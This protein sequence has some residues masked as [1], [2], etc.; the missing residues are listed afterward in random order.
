M[1]VFPL[2][3]QRFPEVRMLPAADAR[4]QAR[5]SH[6]RAR[7]NSNASSS[8]RFCRSFTRSG[9]RQCKKGRRR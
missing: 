8:K 3:L 6:C 1:T 4:E 7:S 2:F 5:A 9:S